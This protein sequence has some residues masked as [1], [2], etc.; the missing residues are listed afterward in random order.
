MCVK[1]VQNDYFGELQTTAQIWNDPCLTGL[2]PQ[3]FGLAQSVRLLARRQNNVELKG[4]VGIL[5]ES[6]CGQDVGLEF[7]EL[8]AAERLD[9][10]V[11]LWNGGISVWLGWQSR[12]V[13]SSL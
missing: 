7:E 1:I 2:V 10:A 5:V 11:R 13:P 9:E 6:D 3:V 4:S 8:L 12:W